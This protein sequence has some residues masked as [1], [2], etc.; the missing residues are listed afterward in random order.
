MA[1]EVE[2]IG[3]GHFSGAKSNIG[4]YTVS[5]ES[6]PVEA[7]DTSGGAGQITFTAV[8]DASRLGSALLLNDTIE[9][10]DGDK[11]VTVGQINSVT[12]NDGVLNITADSRLGRLVMDVTTA[13]ISD[14][15][16]NVIL[17][18][19]E[20]GGITEGIAIDTE[21][22]DIPVKVMGWTGDLWTKI[23]EFLVVHNAEISLVRGDVLIRPV[24][25]RRA[26]EINNASESWSAANVDLSK[27]VE[28]F[29][30]DYHEITDDLVYP[31]GGWRPDLEVHSVDANS[32]KEVNIPIDVSLTDITQPVVQDTVDRFDTGSVYS[33]SGNDGLPIPAQQWIDTGGKLEVSIGED[34]KSIDLKIT[35]PHG[36]IGEKYSPYS[37]AVS[38]GSGEYYSTLRIRGSGI[39][40]TQKSYKVPTG[41]DDSS[42]SRD[43]GTTVDNIFVNTRED[44]QN[45]AQDV[46]AKWSA[47]TRTI[48]ISKADINRP[49][50][51]E[52]RYDYAKFAEWDAFAEDNNIETF[53]DFDSYYAGQTFD[54]FD[55]YW[56]EL[57]KNEFDF[58]V[59]GNANGARIQYRRAMYRIRNADITESGVTY[60]AEADTT[61]GDFDAHAE[62]MTFEDFDAA[63]DGMTFN[64]FSLIPLINVDPEYD[65]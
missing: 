23:K 27:Y 9:L 54:D 31:Y 14:T 30:Y 64:D 3:N 21:L 19:L 41:A 60:T 34:G 61:F 29:Y 50:S 20:L 12:S 62:G 2:L 4:T 52:T 38:S 6:T 55:N 24:R 47:P 59:F 42:T 25:G 10:R 39:G 49:G 53:G 17:Y 13:P 44:A 51:D 63:F 5:E 11:G 36:N 35:G 33:V 16:E 18:Y 45:A 22:R 43:V 28:I 40:F 26:L 57:V 15:F 7:S 8:D 48:N 46:A 37:I 65:R 1:V 56:Y 32:V 58:Q